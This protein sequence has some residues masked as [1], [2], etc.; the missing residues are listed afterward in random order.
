MFDVSQVGRRYFAVRLAASGEDGETRTIDLDVLPPTV[1]VLHQLAEIASKVDGTTD[2]TVIDELRDTVR[3]VLSH[4]RT[5]LKADEY[6]DAMDLDQL[7]AV[8][9]A[10]F[11]WVGQE[12]GAKN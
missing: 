5:G 7:Q 10:Y 3:R 8:L 4:N 9:A 12:R 11:E 6:V 1:K 2:M